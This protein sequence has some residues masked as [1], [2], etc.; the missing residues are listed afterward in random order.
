[1]SEMCKGNE[2]MCQECVREMSSINVYKRCRYG[3]ANNASYDAPTD[4]PN[5]PNDAPKAKTLDHNKGYY[6]ELSSVK[7]DDDSA[8]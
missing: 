5:T 4:T 7:N 1:M 3:A 2:K 6:P 8:Q